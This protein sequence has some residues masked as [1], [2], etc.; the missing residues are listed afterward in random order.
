M[1]PFGAR[2]PRRGDRNAFL[3][4][5]HPLGYRQ[6]L[7]CHLR[8]FLADR[9]GRRLAC[10]LYDFAALYLTLR[11]HWSGWC[12]KPVSCFFREFASNPWPRTS[13]P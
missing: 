2:Q 4:R 8:Y 7:G 13:W 9:Q 6:P 12:D 11:D 3:A 5:Y 1:C 10:L